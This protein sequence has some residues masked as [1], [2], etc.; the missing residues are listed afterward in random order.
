VTL[1]QLPPG[2]TDPESQARISE[3]FK[4]IYEQSS[5]PGGIISLDGAVLNA[6]RAACAVVGVE[7]SQVVGVPFWE[8]PW[9]A[10]SAEE[11]EK[12]RTGIRKAASGEF[13]QFETT[14][15]AADGTT[16]VMDF[17]LRLARDSSGQ[18]LCL[19][20]EARDITETRRAQEERRGSESMMRSVFRATPIGI[21][22]NV[23]RVILSVN[24]SMCELMGYREPEMVGR[25]ARM[26]YDSQEEFD[27]VGREM[28]PELARRGKVSVETRFVRS[29]GTPL[30][31][32]L[33]GAL[34]KSEDPSAGFVVTVQDITTRVRAEEAVREGEKRFRAILE[35]SP[36][37]IQVF[38]PAGDLL[39]MN[40]A[41]EELWGIRKE[42]LTDY[43]LL[44]DPELESHGLMPFIRKAFAGERVTLPVVEY[45]AAAV[46]GRGTQK[47]VQA[48]LYPVRDTGGALREV[49]LVHVDRTERTRAEA[50]SH[51]LQEQLQQAMKMEAVGRLAGG[52]AHDF[53]NL[54]TAIAGNTELAAAGLDPAHP[55]RPHLDEISRAADSAAALTR[56]LLAFSRRQIIEPRVINLNDLVG[57]LRMMLARLLGE[58][59]DLQTSLAEPL[60]SV[61]VDPGQFEQVLVNLAVNAR[62][63]MP[64]GGRL[65]I[66]TANRE[67]DGE[68]C[69][70][71]P[72]AQPGR[73][74]LLAVSDTGHGMSEEVKRRVFE[75][76]FTT[77][78]MGR[79]TGLGLATIFG[80]VK[81][82]SGAIELYSEVGLGTSFKIYLPR[83]E[84]APE[85]LA[86]HAPLREVAHGTETVLLVEDNQSV[87]AL[88]RTL[89]SRLGYTVC[90][91]SNGREA[92][93]LAQGRRGR[94][95]LLL[96]DVVMPG[97][98]GR[99]MAE[100]LVAL[101]PE[102]K[103]LFTSGYTENVIV[104]HGVL[105]ENLNFI[106]KPYT[107]QA[108]S[109][110]IR[111][112]LRP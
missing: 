75:P 65:V 28:Y 7:P 46:V 102:M 18:P 77:K 91:A 12:L 85:R 112:V 35:Q 24:D 94:I 25:S 72:Q 13:V 42:S 60:D 84:A 73:Y 45:N 66:E 105:E 106:G 103:V 70:G 52:I 56:Q 97:M 55:V 90:E 54:L 34:L 48:I 3:I 26:F 108:L 19:I 44:R 58:D 83:V 78:P 98:N 32:I 62:D 17:A 21:T 37:S 69:A 93:E 99:E 22:F 109:E 87:R 100:R 31:V 51:R 96:T 15:P 92:I 49:I 43:N 53:N 59:V 11:Q 71:H 61:K 40:A 110:K 6:N 104:H 107:M 20:A 5:H 39:E 27:R 57:H 82:A 16:R 38:S 30:F 74:V 2:R 47:V 64:D 95:D 29:D 88:A 14:L 81:Q 80:I 79:G 50:E 10:H 67:L 111:A 23:N 89:L 4:A 101:H 86:G 76:F 63:A 36:F 1:S 33:T 68:Y 41:C 8:T 9:W